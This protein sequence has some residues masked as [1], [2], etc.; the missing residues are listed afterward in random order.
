MNILLVKIQNSFLIQNN[1]LKMLYN[2]LSNIY[3]IKHFKVYKILSIIY[4][5]LSKMKKNNNK[6]NNM[7]KKVIIIIKQ[8]N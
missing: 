7:I 8:T 4:Y 1:F 5:F 6:L 2:L 3:F